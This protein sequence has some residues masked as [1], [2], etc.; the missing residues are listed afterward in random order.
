MTAVAL[1]PLVDPRAGQGKGHDPTGGQPGICIRSRRP[2]E[3]VCDRPRVE[4]TT[5]LVPVQMLPGIGIETVPEDSGKLRRSDSLVDALPQRFRVH[6]NLL[7]VAPVF[8]AVRTLSG[9]RNLPAHGVAS[10]AVPANPARKC[11]IFSIRGAR[12]GRSP[13]RSIPCQAS[14]RFQCRVRPGNPLPACLPD[15]ADRTGPAPRRTTSGRMQVRRSAC[16]RR[17]RPRPA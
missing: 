8:V 9:D 4:R 17:S 13:L 6:S 2:E 11:R 7:S 5:L 16:R 3:G 14:F 15:A 12:S 1:P 10:R